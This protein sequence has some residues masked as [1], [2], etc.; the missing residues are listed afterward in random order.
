LWITFSLLA[1]NGKNA[2]NSSS[3]MNFNYSIYLPNS[4]FKELFLVFS[5]D[6]S[7]KFGWMEFLLVM[8]LMLLFSDFFFLVGGLNTCEYL[9]LSLQFFTVECFTL[10]RYFL[11][12]EFLCLTIVYFSI[13]G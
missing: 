6:G 8:F 10:P 11:C 9:R 13:L 5:F 7:S 3:S 12:V 4:I 2:L 1:E